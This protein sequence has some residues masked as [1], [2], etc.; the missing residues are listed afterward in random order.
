MARAH[1]RARYDADEMIADDGL[2]SAADGFFEALGM[3]DL[4]QL[5]QL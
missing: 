5:A 4:L 2:T 1:K 3:C